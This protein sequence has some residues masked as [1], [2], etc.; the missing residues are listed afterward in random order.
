MFCFTIRKQNLVVCFLIVKQASSVFISSQ[1]ALG[2][3]EFFYS[4]IS[5][6]RSHVSERALP[7]RNHHPCSAVYI[8]LTVP[9]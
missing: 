1:L 7:M 5:Y 3:P 4:Q 8:S 2:L 6:G 9:R